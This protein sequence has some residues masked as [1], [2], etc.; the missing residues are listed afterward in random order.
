MTE[1]DSALA[2]YNIPDKN[3]D[4]EQRAVEGPADS[5]W[6]DSNAA[7]VSVK[8]F[9]AAQTGHPRLTMLIR[10]APGSHYD[11]SQHHGGEEFLV[12]EGSIRD[13]KGQYH[14]GFYVRNPTGT[15]HNPISDDGCLLFLKLG[16]FSE[17]DQ[18]HRIIDTNDQEAWLPG[19]IDGTR[20]LPL[21]MHDTRSVFMI[22]WDE[23]T[24]FKPGIDPQGEEI[25]V[26][27]GMLQDSDGSYHAG[28][29][30]RNPI[31]AWQTWK[32][33]KDSIAYYKNGHFP[34]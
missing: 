6:L 16:E 8:F 1:P 3:A 31:S 5:P 2:R 10:F 11:L 9:E 15:P 20:V 33:Y 34:K 4:F 22:R 32:G 30:I 23:E 24:E 7:G 25:Y 18:E 26:T 28:S 19:P 29:W 14:P 12:L 27:H 13:E 17:E 21:H